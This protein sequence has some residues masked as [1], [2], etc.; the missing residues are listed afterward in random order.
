MYK[1]WFGT[2]TKKLLNVLPCCCPDSAY[3]D[4]FTLR[5]CLRKLS[6]SLIK[7]LKMTPDYS[8]K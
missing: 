8:K 5:K 7:T 4:P 6:L 2:C 1:V 3:T